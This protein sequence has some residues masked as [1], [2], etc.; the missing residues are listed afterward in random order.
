MQKTLL[1][2][3]KKSDQIE[4]FIGRPDNAAM[5]LQQTSKTQDLE[6][7]KDGPDR[8]MQRCA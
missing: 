3:G 2:G 8:L 4:G 7:L 6:Q 5:A 1:T